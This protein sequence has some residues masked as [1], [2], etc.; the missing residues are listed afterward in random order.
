[1]LGSG[2]RR[3]FS[4]ASSARSRPCSLRGSLVTSI[5]SK[6]HLRSHFSL[7]LSVSV[8]HSHSASGS[9]S[10]SQLLPRFLGLELDTLDAFGIHRPAHDDDGD[11]NIAL[12]LPAAASSLPS[13]SATPAVHH[14]WGAE[15]LSDRLRADATI[16]FVDMFSLGALNVAF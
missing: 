4:C 12:S 6:P 1:M 2:C 9:H 8:S 15:G 11:L 10:L 3:S 5:H 16:A 13:R 14:A 7:S